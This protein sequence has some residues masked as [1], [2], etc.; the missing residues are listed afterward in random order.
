MRT[1]A[2][3]GQRHYIWGMIKTSGLDREGYI[4]TTIFAEVETMKSIE[5]LSYLLLTWVSLVVV[6]NA[7]GK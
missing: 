7:Q 1:G 5:A 6:R 4:T 2:K 3:L